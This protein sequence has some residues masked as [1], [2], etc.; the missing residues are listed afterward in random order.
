MTVINFSE[1]MAAAMN[2]AIKVGNLIASGKWATEI[3]TKPHPTF[4]T[5][6]FTEA[7]TGGQLIAIAKLHDQ[8]PDATFLAEEEGNPF[9]GDFTGERAF[10]LD[11]IDGTTPNRRKLFQ[12]CSAIGVGRNGKHVGGVIH[13]PEVRGGLTIAGERGIGVFLW[14]HGAAEPA[15]VSIGARDPKPLVYL[16]I[17]VSRT[18]TYGKFVTA[19]PKNLKP[20]GIAESGALGLALVAA[21]RIDA[22]VQSP[23]MPWDWCG[24]M[25]MVLEADGAFQCFHVV[26][27]KIEPVQKLGRYDY[28]TDQQVL[29]FVAGHPEL[30]PK[31]FDI[32]QKNVGAD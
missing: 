30:V 12:W 19:L 18:D 1:E 24:G 9:P 6:S 17:D 3:K 23:Q 2:T 22:I 21:G 4:E 28:D 31:L 26:D 29:G 14:E 10:S 27:G 13:A 20:R 11:P 5:A 16:G 8:F 25:P 7:D 15:Q 32:L